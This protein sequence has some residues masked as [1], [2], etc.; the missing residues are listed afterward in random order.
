[1]ERNLLKK[2][3]F[4]KG[5]AALWK[6]SGKN[7]H[8]YL[9]PICGKGQH[10]DQITSGGLSLEHVPSAGLGG[11]ELV[12]ICRPCK[13]ASDLPETFAFA[14]HNRLNPWQGAVQGVDPFKISVSTD[15]G[16]DM[17]PEDASFQWLLKV[18]DLKT[19]F[20]ACFA[21]FGYRYVFNEKLKS[22]RR[23]ILDSSAHLIDGF[24]IMMED[25]K[26]AGF[27]IVLMSDP[28]RSVAVRIGNASVLLPWVSGPDDIYDML[29]KK[30]RPEDKILISGERVRWPESLEMRLDF[31]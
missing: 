29:L 27:E 8:I 30:Y 1:M 15:H 19:A 7:R 18:S 22:V 23:Q 16:F 26:K 24:W 11:K 25:D 2:R 31:V 5:A 12:L 14:D 10:E 6:V 20:L 4:E 17:A 28:V 9:C 3:I 21:S 13:D